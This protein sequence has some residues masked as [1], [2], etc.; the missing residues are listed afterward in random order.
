MILPPPSHCVTVSSAAAMFGRIISFSASNLKALLPASI[1]RCTRQLHIT[2]PVAV[3]QIIETRKD[4]QLIIEG[5]YM[6]SPR[7]ETLLRHNEDS[8]ACAVCR[9]NVEI[10]H[11]DVLILSQFIRKDGCMLPR[12]ITGLC[13]LQQRRIGN[14]VAM[15]NKAG[16]MTS[17]LPRARERDPYKRRKEHLKFKV[18]YDE[19]TIKPPKDP[20]APRK[21]VPKDNWF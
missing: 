13:R 17:L 3:K 10:K 12:R 7:E 4:K 6:N 9:L 1:S 19:S 15:A 5:V 14:M 16:L 11:T 18:Y 20:F 2:A 8:D 21:L